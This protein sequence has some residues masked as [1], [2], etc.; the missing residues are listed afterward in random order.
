[1]RQTVNHQTDSWDDN[2]KLRY[3][4]A[5]TELVPVI[6]QSQGAHPGDVIGAVGIDACKRYNLQFVG[7]LGHF[8]VFLVQAS[9]ALSPLC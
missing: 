1:M 3:Q 6:R 4:T 8:D 5:S 7:N 9:D 2:W